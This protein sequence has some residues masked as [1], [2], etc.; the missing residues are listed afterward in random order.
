MEFTYT[1]YKHDP[2]A[3][4]ELKTIRLDTTTRAEEL[5]PEHVKDGK[6]IEVYCNRTNRVLYT[7]HTEDELDDYL[8]SRAR[9]AAWLPKKASTE[10]VIEASPVLTDSTLSST[11]SIEKKDAINPS[12]YKGFVSLEDG[13]VL[14]WLETMQYLPRFRN[15]ES[16]KAALELQVRKYLDRNG[17]KDAEMQELMKSLWYFKF[18][19][20]FIANGEKPIR[21]ADIPKL[22]GEKNGA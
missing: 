18:L 14:Q 12:H 7:L 8:E 4:P 1:I 3:P 6:Y 13:T 22:L 19:V 11:T 16:F 10:T 20:A 2:K 15:P 5:K 17:G 21:V 9:A